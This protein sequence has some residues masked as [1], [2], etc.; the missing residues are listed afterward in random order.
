MWFN[1]YVVEGTKR[2]QRSGQTARRE[3][4]MG[5]GTRVVAEDGR[6]HT[7]TY[8]WD[9]KQEVVLVTYTWTDTGLSLDDGDT[10]LVWDHDGST[11]TDKTWKR[12]VFDD[13]AVKGYWARQTP[14]RFPHYCGC[15]CR[16][17]TKGGRFVPGHDAKLAETHSKTRE[18]QQGKLR[19]WHNG[20]DAN[21]LDSW[22]IAT[23]GQMVETVGRVLVIGTTTERRVDMT[24]TRKSGY[25]RVST[26]RLQVSVRF[27]YDVEVEIDEVI[28]IRKGTRSAL[29][30]CMRHLQ[31]GAWDYQVRYQLEREA[32]ELGIMEWRIMDCFDTVSATH[33]KN[34]H[35][36]V[37]RERD[38][39]GM[40]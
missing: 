28:E 13:L 14:S 3:T 35:R 31:V 19:A 17:V 39:L 18:I 8:N 7:A 40:G 16:A 20:A 22:T 32:R 6:N 26:T 15:G 10:M 12:A 38:R 21:G 34:L 30:E 9:R 5:K 36:M 11:L 29:R 1:G 4:A 2:E 27:S 25:R 37:R 33:I 24:G 23:R